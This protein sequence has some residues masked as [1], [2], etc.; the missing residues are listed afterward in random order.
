MFEKNS[1]P[2]TQYHCTCTPN[3]Q[4]T[5]KFKSACD[6]NVIVATNDELSDPDFFD[7]GDDGEIVFEDSSDCDLPDACADFGCAIEKGIKRKPTPVV[8]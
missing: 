8:F 7:E 3:E 6:R 5:C 4:E 1:T 2:P